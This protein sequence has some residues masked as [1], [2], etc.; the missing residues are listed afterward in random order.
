MRPERVWYLAY[1]SNVDRSRFMRYLAGGV[2]EPG[3]RD[4][5]PPRQHRWVRAPLRLTFARE[6]VRWEGGGVAFVHSDPAGDAIVRAWDIS[7]AQFEDVFAQ[8]N[9]LPV[10]TALDWSALRAGSID[11]GGGWYRRVLR[12]P[13][14]F[15]ADRQPAL[16]FTWHRPRPSRTPHP[17]YVATIRDGLRQHPQLDDAAVDQYLGRN[18]AA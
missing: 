18:G 14:G 12:V 4:A 3:A 7:S 13:L 17:S 5:A 9:R 6:S 16:T 8:E 1:G 2:T 10:G 11:H 15:A